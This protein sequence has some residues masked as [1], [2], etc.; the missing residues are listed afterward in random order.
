MVQI[1][2]SK[3]ENAVLVDHIQSANRLK[4]QVEQLQTQAMRELRDAQIT[5]LAIQRR[6]Q[7]EVVDKSIQFPD[8][9]GIKIEDSVITC[10][11][12]IKDMPEGN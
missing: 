5:W 6:Y 7:L 2:L 9:D 11:V 4:A 3:E 1:V 12:K 10:D 8:I